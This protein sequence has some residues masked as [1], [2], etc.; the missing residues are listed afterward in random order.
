[1]A[2]AARLE[3]SA[4]CYITVARDARGSACWVVVTPDQMIRCSSGHRAL[5]V[6]EAQITSGRC[7]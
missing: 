6:L 7:Q 5:A 2:T 4:Q 1:M 3:Q